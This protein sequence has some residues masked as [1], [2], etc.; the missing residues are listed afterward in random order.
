MQFLSRVEQAGRGKPRPYVFYGLLLAI[1][2][3]EF[4]LFQSYVMREIVPFY[5]SSNDQSSYLTHA[6]TLY[7][8]IAQQGLLTG[9]FQ[10]SPGPTS[11]LFMPQAALFFM[12][13]GASRFSALLL[14]FFYFI[15]F[16]LAFV[17]TVKTLSRNIFIPLF[18]LGLLLACRIP[19]DVGGLLD[20][21]IDFMAFCLYGI[22]LSC[23]LLSRIFLERR[24][25]IVAALCAVLLILMRSITV[26]YLGIL[27]ILLL[28]WFPWT[29]HAAIRIK[30]LLLFGLIVVLMVLPVLWMNWQAIYEYYGMGHLLG[31][32]KHIRA[33]EMG[34]KNLWNVLTFYPITLRTH[35]K[36]TI[37]AI[38]FI[39]LLSI[40]YGWFRCRSRSVTLPLYREGYIFLILAILAPLIPLTLDV[41]K[42][43]VVAG[44]LVPPVL[45]FL[46]WALMHIE[47]I[48]DKNP[49]MTRWLQIFF[50]L[51]L[52]TGLGFQLDK[53]ALRAVPLEKKQEEAQITQM[54]EDIG[55]YARKKQWPQVRLSVDRICDYLLSGNQVTLYYERKGILLD[56]AIQRLGDSIFSITKEEALASLEKSNVLILNLGDYKKGPPYPF[57]SDVELLK[58]LLKQVAERDFIKLKDYTFKDSIYRVYVRS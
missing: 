2:V 20:F 42:S 24:W 15:A 18:A 11:T 36:G 25:V 50:V 21:R 38:G 4:L 54:Y 27:G 6:Y 57:N 12:L 10:Y 13:S 3:F 30:N 37:W 33:K 47:T 8:K 17:L 41:S 45:W 46:V 9:L 32:E 7:E 5:P 34:I 35:L 49:G 51:V 43:S 44:I 55:D 28:A 19:F 22:F 29:Q 48:C 52:V 16:Q 40:A 56:V 1:F 26:A 39:W 23:V 14:N 58:P 53:L 31:E